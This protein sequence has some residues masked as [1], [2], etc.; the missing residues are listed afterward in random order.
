MRRKY[1]VEFKRK[2]VKQVLEAEKPSH[3]AR[4]HKLSS[5]TIY[6]WISEY[7]QGK[8]NLNVNRN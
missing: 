6:R 7:K 3:V 5:I 2:V 8:Y 1:S 4:K